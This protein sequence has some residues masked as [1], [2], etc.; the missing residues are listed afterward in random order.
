MAKKKTDRKPSFVHYGK[1]KKEILVGE[2]HYGSASDS[3]VLEKGKGVKTF[4]TDPPYNLGDDSF[5][6]NDKIVDEED[7][8][9]HSK[10]L[11]FMKKRLKLIP[12]NRMA[13]PGEISKY[14][15]DLVTEKNSFMTGQTIT[16]SGGE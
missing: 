16:V 6:Y 13:E 9:R 8:Y 7:S 10:W 2:F 5:K 3:K 1:G 11:S 15:N 12:M 4:L 14:I